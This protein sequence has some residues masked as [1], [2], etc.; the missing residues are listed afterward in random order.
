VFSW[1]KPELL[2]VS[3]AHECVLKMPHSAW[4]IATTIPAEFADLL[5]LL[6]D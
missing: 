1:P 5:R 6:P 2:E 4:E 3:L